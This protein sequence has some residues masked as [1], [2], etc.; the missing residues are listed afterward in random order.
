MFYSR[1]GSNTIIVGVTFLTISYSFLFTELYKSC[2]CFGDRHVSRL[3]PPYAFVVN[4]QGQADNRESPNKRQ[5]VRDRKRLVL[6]ND[7]QCQLVF[8]FVCL[9]V[10]LLVY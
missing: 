3:L 8:L 10:L 4:K 9:T 2:L 5:R 6:Q 7:K 1:S